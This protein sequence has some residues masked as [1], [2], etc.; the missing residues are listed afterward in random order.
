MRLGRVL[1]ATLLAPDIVEA[2]LDGR[3]PELSLPQLMQPFP[4]EWDFQRA[5]WVSAPNNQTMRLRAHRQGIE[6]DPEAL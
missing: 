3:Q 4:L 5:K 1:L 2:I 6:I